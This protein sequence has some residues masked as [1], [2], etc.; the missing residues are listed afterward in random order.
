M[1]RRIRHC[2]RTL[3]SPL[4]DLLYPPVCVHNHVEL[5][6]P[7]VGPPLSD[8]SLTQLFPS[9]RP[10]CPKCGV[11]VTSSAATVDC[12]RCRGRRFPFAAVIPLG[13]Y[14]GALRSAVLRMKKWHESPLT[15]ALGRLLGERCAATFAESSA[16]DR[17][18]AVVALPMPWLRRLVRGINSP[19]LIAD[20]VAAALDVPHLTGLL[21]CRR[22]PQ[23]QALLPPSQRRANVHGV[24]GCTQKY[25]FAGA[26]LLLVDDIMT[27]GATVIEASRALRDAGAARVTV[28]VIARAQQPD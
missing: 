19:E 3:T 12:P 11:E 10:T 1:Q 13:S 25:A 20:E 28:A 4:I 27:T 23:K 5:A 22:M 24:Y 26:H 6:E 16:E 8:Q 2:W 7:P 21:R 17:P 9:R 15:V 14:E 18:D